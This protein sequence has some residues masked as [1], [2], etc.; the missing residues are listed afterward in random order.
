MSVLV[1]DVSKAL[2]AIRAISREAGD[3]R[4]AQS[5]PVEF[6]PRILDEDK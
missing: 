5:P 1:V 3:E 4:E 2:R 6:S